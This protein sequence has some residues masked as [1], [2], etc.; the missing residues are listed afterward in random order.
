MTYQTKTA[1]DANGQLEVLTFDIGEECLAVEATIIREIL[2]LLPETRV[3][4]AP[5]LAGSVVNFRGKVIPISDLRIAF[6]LPLDEATIES[7]I[8]VIEAELDGEPTYIGLRTDKVHE[9]T[10]LNQAESSAPP[11][12]GMRWN[13]DYVRELVRH[14]GNVIVL[15]DLSAIFREPD[16]GGATDRRRT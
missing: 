13:R 6:G 16:Q 14:H 4:G 11:Q 10:T 15:P 8:V 7:R 12:V 9:V 1:W 2:D 5:A 3:P